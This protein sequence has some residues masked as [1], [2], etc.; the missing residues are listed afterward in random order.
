MEGFAQKGIVEMR[1]RTP[2]TKFVDATFRNKT[3]DMGVP[4]EIAAK[5]VKDANETRDEMAR[6]INVEKEAGDYLI[7]GRKEQV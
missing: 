4:F 3:V 6:V 5:C 1:N 7:N 2:K